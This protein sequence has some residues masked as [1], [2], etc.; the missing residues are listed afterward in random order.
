MEQIELDGRAVKNTP[1]SVRWR[2]P[3]FL[4]GDG[5]GAPSYAP[6]WTV[7]I[8]FA[9]TSRIQLQH[10]YEAMDGDT[11]TIRLAHPVTGVWTDF[12]SVYV[13]LPEVQMTT[14]DARR[15]SASGVDFVITHVSVS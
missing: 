13:R 3:N 4:G 10:W 15:P 9:R 5:D 14:I 8:G 1:T 12:T 2:P 11:H 6:F 7:E